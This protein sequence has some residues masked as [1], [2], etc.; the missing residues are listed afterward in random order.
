LNY[1]DG[2]HFKEKCNKCHGWKEHEY[3]PF[4]YKTKPCPAGK[5]CAKGRD[6]PHFHH[7]MERRMVTPNVLNRIFRY[8]PRNRIVTNTFKVRSNASYPMQNQSLNPSYSSVS[9]YSS[10]TLLQ[11]NDSFMDQYPSL[12]EQLSGT[13]SRGGT[14]NIGSDLSAKGFGQR[15]L[16]LEELTE[17]KHR[18]QSYEFEYGRQRT[19]S[20]LATN[21]YKTEIVPPGLDKTS[22]KNINSKAR[23]WSTDDEGGLNQERDRLFRE[24][25]M[26][27]FKKESSKEEIIENPKTK[28]EEKDE[29]RAEV[30]FKNNLMLDKILES[31]DI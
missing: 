29:A 21:T 25:F 15:D 16:G 5:N 3:H 6:C 30:E 28:A 12:S 9:T 14:L 10:L 7:L 19:L 8:V 22:E 24:I 23:R 1:E 17:V 13:L 26:T 2:C 31:E 27:N 20:G 11:E 18:K 4:N